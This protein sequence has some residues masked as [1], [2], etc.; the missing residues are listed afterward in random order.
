MSKKNLIWLL[1]IA[2]GIALCGIFYQYQLQWTMSNSSMIV[3]E[4]AGINNTASASE[5][6]NETNNTA[7]NQ[8]ALTIPLEKPPFIE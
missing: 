3:T 2:F 6:L 4:I 1:I 8:S 7:T 5:E